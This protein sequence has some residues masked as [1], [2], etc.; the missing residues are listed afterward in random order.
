M[1]N[2]ARYG[3]IAAAVVLLVGAGVV[4]LRPAPAGVAAPCHAAPTAAASPS[5]SP[6]EAVAASPTLRP[7]AA[8]PGPN[9]LDGDGGPALILTV[10]EATLVG[11]IT[12]PTSRR[13]TVAGGAGCLPGPG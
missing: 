2:L 13:T 1:S 3:V 10:P 8:L 12:G 6:T 9:R 4:L 11:V 5:P 7:D